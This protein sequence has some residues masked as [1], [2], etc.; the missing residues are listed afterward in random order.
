MTVSNLAELTEILRD[1]RGDAL[2]GAALVKT[3]FGIAIAIEM[4]E[5]LSQM[6]QSGDV[7]FMWENGE[8]TTV[9]EDDEIEVLQAS[10]WPEER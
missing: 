10:V 3:D 6:W 9:R 2:V 4:G 1:N 8:H 5:N 7:L